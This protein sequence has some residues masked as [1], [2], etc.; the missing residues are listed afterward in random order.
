MTSHE[1][2]ATQATHQVPEKK[3]TSVG[4]YVVGPAKA[5]EPA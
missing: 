2:S 4:L 5:M 1:K 3:Q